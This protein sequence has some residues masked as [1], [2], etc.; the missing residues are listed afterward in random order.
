MQ[1]R[2]LCVAGVLAVG[3]IAHAATFTNPAAITIVDNAN[4]SLYP[5]TITI[6]NTGVIQS[7]A[8]SLAGITHQRLADLTILLVSPTGR[9]IQLMANAPGTVTALSPLSFLDAGQPIIGGQLVKT[10]YRPTVNPSPQSMPAPAP[11]L[12]YETSFDSLIG[13]S[14]TGVW[15]LYIRDNVTGE[16]GTITG[17][18]SITFNASS[19]TPVHSEFVYQGFLKNSSGA[20]NGVYDVRADLWR[21][22]NS[23][24]ASDK[25]ASV[26]SFNVPVSNGVFTARFAPPE[27]V[28]TDARSLWVEI[29]VKGPSDA[30]FETLSPRAPISAVPFATY[31]MFS[32][33]TELAGQAQSVEWANITGIPSNV[34]NA[35]SPWASQ[36]GNA[37]NSTNT[38]NVLIGTTSGTSK[39]TVNG[40]IEST[41]GGIKFPDD[42]VQTTAAVSPVVASQSV[43]VNF[44]SIA[45]GGESFATVTFA[46]AT[47]LTSDVAVVSPQSLLP[48]D[49]G[50]QLARVTS[51][52]QVQFVIR[53][54]GTVAADPPAIVFNVKVIR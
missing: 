22:P 8:V 40:T 29:A 9:K 36:A 1:I 12:P 25:V 30:S 39:L 51:G 24:F 37:I 43:S 44:A 20:L 2:N 49:V 26:T 48:S 52:T 45:A 15:S 54:H 38:G 13:E 4:A 41:S 5:S 34:L 50:I 47:L 31:A 21:S 32:G 7:A 46:G 23:V 17:G 42:T 28:I 33:F 53:N 10:P 35:F 3:A 16:A 27:N 19:L 6:P 14:I 11:G 18:W